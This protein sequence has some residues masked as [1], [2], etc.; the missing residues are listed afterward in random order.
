MRF[1]LEHLEVNPEGGKVDTSRADNRKVY[2]VGGGIAGLASA[3]Y[4]IRDG[5]LRGEQISIFEEAETMGGSLDASGSA[6]T[7]YIMR[8][9]RMFDAQYVCTYD[10]LSEIPSYDNGG[11]S[12]RNDIFDFTRQASWHA[13]RRLIDH[14]GNAIDVSSMGFDNRDRLALLW[15]ILR[16]EHSLGAKQIIDVLPQHFFTTNFWLMWCTMFAFQPWHSASEMRRYLL[17]F[18]HL[19]PTLG[20]MTGIYKPRYN[21]YHAIVVPVQRWLQ[22]RGV[23]F[24]NETRVVALEFHSSPDHHHAKEIRVRYN[25]EEREFALDEDDLVVFTNGSMTAA[26]TLGSMQMPAVLDRGEPGGAWT[27]WESLATKRH[28]FGRPEV[29]ANNIDQS[30]W[31]SF[32]ATTALP[33]LR[34]LFEKMTNTAVGRQGLITFKESNWLMTIAPRYCPAYPGQPEDVVIWWGYGLNPDREGNFVKKRMADCTGE[35]LLHEVFLHLH[36]EDHLDELMEHSQAIPCMMPYITSQFMPRVKGDRPEVIPPGSKNFAFVGQF[37]EVPD[38]MVFTVE[39]SV[40][41]AKM[42]VNA[43]LGLTRPIPPVY[44]GWRNP[45]VVLRAIKETL[46]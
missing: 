15:L 26:S 44:K 21:E 41:T 17:R 7:G 12:A 13:T 1:A 46:R 8:G 16:C 36:F 29:F 37:C 27:L 19:F 24:A 38:D 39:Y 14:E 4:L 6:E 18:M 22:E 32:T 23:E 40:R 42:A 10:L 5:G 43:L 11:I 28:G 34:Q 2:I 9:G 30:K 35:D 31:L 3:V 45:W 20:T 25:Q 33:L